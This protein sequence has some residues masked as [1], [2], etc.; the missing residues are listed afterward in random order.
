MSK[1]VAKIHHIENI[2]YPVAVYLI[3]TYIKIMHLCRAKYNSSHNNIFLHSFLPN[4]LHEHSH[5]QTKYP[6]HATNQLGVYLSLSF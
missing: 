2:N 1:V 6:Q 5:L 3:T 4:N